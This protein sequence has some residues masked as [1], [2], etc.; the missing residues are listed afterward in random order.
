MI[1]AGGGAGRFAIPGLF[2][3]HVHGGPP[4]AYVA[5]GVPHSSLITSSYT[6]LVMMK[7]GWC[8]SVLYFGRR[9]SV[10]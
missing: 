4:A 8:M 6:S 5:Y 10:L 2:D 9:R 7:S 3:M 1:A